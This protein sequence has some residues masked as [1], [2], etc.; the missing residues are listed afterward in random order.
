MM[1]TP[2]NKFTSTSLVGV[3]FCF[4]ISYSFLPH[5]ADFLIPIE[6]GQRANFLLASLA[7]SNPTDRA[8]LHGLLFS[9][10]FSSFYILQFPLSFGF[11]AFVFR[12]IHYTMLTPTV[13]RF[14]WYLQDHL[15]YAI[16]LLHD[17]GAVLSVFILST[18][19]F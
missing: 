15:H 11:R 18:V 4:I 16:L 1:R 14:R 10:S 17:G 2:E 12:I 3:F 13:Y 9:R 19:L 7:A 8:W 6:Q 5:F